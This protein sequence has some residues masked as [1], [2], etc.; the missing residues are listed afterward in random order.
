M[1]LIVTAN[2]VI[3]HLRLNYNK[4]SDAIN[5]YNANH[6]ALLVSNSI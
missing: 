4:G 2:A 1:R 5:G 6:R 3:H